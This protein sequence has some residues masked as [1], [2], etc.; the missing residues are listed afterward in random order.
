MELHCTHV[1]RLIYIAI[2]DLNINRVIFVNV[3]KVRLNCLS[4]MI[5]INLS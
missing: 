4:V 3:Q 1:L 2:E 5:K